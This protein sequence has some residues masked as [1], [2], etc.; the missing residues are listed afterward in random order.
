MRRDGFKSCAVC[1]ERKNHL[2]HPADHAFQDASSAG[3]NGI[4]AS[5]REYLASKEHRDAYASARAGDVGGGVCLA[6]L[7]GAPGECSGDRV[8]HHVLGRGA[9]GGLEAAERDAVVVMVCSYFNS[10]VE[11]DPRVRR[12]AE[13]TT[14]ERGGVE[15]PFRMRAAKR[16]IEEM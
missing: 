9:A 16:Q 3:M 6:H 15:Y 7:A 10:T 5:R 2:N 13:R 14:F 4:S 11:S 1:H 12:W 8:P